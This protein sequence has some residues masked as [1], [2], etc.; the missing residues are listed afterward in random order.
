MRGGPGGFGGPARGIP[1][2]GAGPSCRRAPSRSRT[3]GSRTCTPARLAGANGWPRPTTAQAEWPVIMSGPAR[4]PEEI[5]RPEDHLPAR[6]AG[7]PAPRGHR[8]RDPRPPGRDRRRRDRVG[9]DHPAPEDLPRARP[10]P[11]YL[12][13]KG[14]DGEAATQRRPDRAHP[15][16]PDRRPLGGRADRRGARRPSSATWWAT[17]CGSPTAP[18]RSS[19]VKLMTDGILLAELQRDRMLRRYD[20]IIIDEAHERSLNI[21][22]LLGYLRRLLPKRPDLQ[23]RHHLGHHRPRAVR[24]ALRGPAREA[25]ADHRGLRAHLPRR[26]PLPPAGA[27]WPEADEEGETVV[28][29][30]TEAIVDAVKELSA[31]GPGDILVFLP[32]EREIRDTA[33][34]LVRP[35]R[36]DPRAAASRSCRS[37]PGSRPPSSTG[38]SQP[39]TGRRVVL[40]TNV[41]E[42]SLTVPGIRYVVDS[43]VARISRYSA[44]TKVQR[45]PIEPISQASANQRSGR[46][47]RRRGR[48]RD[49]A[50][51][52]GGLRGPPGVHRPRD[53]ADQPRRRSSCR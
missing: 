18:A 43:G 35:D 48:H 50:L 23:A 1:A 3:D 20:T 42:T 33:D 15:A 26:G 11:S 22:F 34:A 29:D 52:R 39:H 19:R 17:R 2:R 49:P 21:D 25:R 5:G 45:L 51:L 44:R 37:T 28:R 8:R 7:H 40:A 14:R 38:C 46:C 10:R 9:Q 24:P 30:Q 27:S 4:A 16:A 53:P 13:G 31:E 47:G 12:P 32:G 36:V 41:A 6:A